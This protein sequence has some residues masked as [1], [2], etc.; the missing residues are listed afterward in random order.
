V[1]TT[2]SF[3]ATIAVKASPFSQRSATPRGALGPTS[4]EPPTRRAR[5]SR[6]APG[7]RTSRGSSS[8]SVTY[9]CSNP[10]RPVPVREVSDVTPSRL[11]T[12]STA[13]A[14]AGCSRANSVS[15][16]A[17]QDVFR[18][19]RRRFWRR[20]SPLRQSADRAEAGKDGKVVE[21]RGGNG[22][23]TVRAFQAPYRLNKPNLFGTCCQRLPPKSHGKECHE[24][25]PPPV[26][27]S[28]LST[29]AIERRP[30]FNVVRRFGSQP[31]ASRLPSTGR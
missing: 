6:R 19:F 15:Q 20:P 16:N 4:R 5:L 11:E 23:Q 12:G 7:L 9:D 1:L 21:K 2:A 31:Q 24:G 10:D 22:A 29:G 27:G 25:G 28:G 30:E 26:T 17:Y 13:N 14:V 18:A 8:R 3:R